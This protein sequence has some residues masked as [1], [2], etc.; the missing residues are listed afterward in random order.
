M[1]ASRFHICLPPIALLAVFLAPA[2]ATAAQYVVD[3]ISLGARVAPDDPNYTSFACK[4][5]DDVY[6]ATRCDR[7]QQRN[8]KG[9]TVPVTNAFIYDQDGTVIYTMMGALAAAL[10]KS[11]VQAEVQS[12]SSQMN[13]K[14]A[15]VNWPDLQDGAPTAVFATWGSVKLEEVG[16]TDLSDIADGKDPH[17]GVLVDALGDLPT[18][19]KKGFH[20]YRVTGGRGYLYMASF[21]ANG[22]GRKRYIA[23]DPADFAVRQFQAALQKLL[24]QDRSLAKDD[25]RLWPDV[26]IITRV[27]ARDTSP[28]VANDAL[29]A[30]F[31]NFPAKKLQS[32][33]WALIPSGAILRLGANIYSRLDQYGPAT[34]HPDVRTAIQSFL[35]S[36]QPDPFIEFAYYI[37]GDFDKALSANP[38]SVIA[39][40]LHYAA[41]Y[42]IMGSL[43]ANTLP[44]ISAHLTQTAEADA[45]D[46]LKSLIADSPDAE[47]YVASGLGFANRNHDLYGNGLL[48][49]FNPDFAARAAAAK[50]HFEA[51]MHE[52]SMPLAD[53]AA[54]MLGWLAH[55]QGKLDEAMA[56]LS[57]GMIIG[58]GDYG[59]AATKEAIRILVQYPARQQFALVESHPGFAKQ[60]ALWY[61]AARAA[62]RDF[63]FALAGEIANHGLNALKVPADS[64]PQ[65][66]DPDRIEAAIQK[67]DPDLAVDPN[68]V[69]LPYVIQAS[70]EISQYLEF[71]N[72]AGA[73]QPDVLYKRAR[74]TIIK[75]SMIIDPSFRPGGDRLPHVLAH[76]D[77]RQALHLIDATFD[78]TAKNPAHGRLREWLYYRKTRIMAVY[79]PER[80]GDVVEAMKGEFPDSKLLDDAMAEQIYAQGIEMADPQAARKTFQALLAAFPNGNAV[81]NAYS[82]MSI[83]LR[84]ACKTDEEQTIERDLIRRFPL[85]RHAR[86]ARER[87]AKPVRCQ[88]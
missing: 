45:V 66:T 69:E 27:L 35:A 56:D 63:D 12:L 9:A 42:K 65:T 5:A 43:L 46:Q 22:R 21:D 48:A 41:G 77:L 75:Y 60:P 17:L 10:T 87:L 33:V 37:N 58:N 26:A 61:L 11:V 51:V 88:S 38:K 76:R 83:I 82:W 4:P 67:I 72:S 40:V 55:H 62:Y 54:Y 74:A 23:I 80:T 53:D 71:L 3:G 31:K 73:Q 86:Y 15:N 16:G 81:D 1:A 59:G 70:K 68:A 50:P 6:N 30:I 8:I 49:S 78:K 39:N 19:A 52:P 29:D 32:H 25:Y 20:I 24:Q 79:Q 18:S 14:P 44:T 57:Q 85:T 2:A 7:R 28:K 36:K 34:E 84:T 47:Y 64:L 13:E